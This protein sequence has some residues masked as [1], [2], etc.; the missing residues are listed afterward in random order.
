MGVLGSSGCTPGVI[1]D[2]PGVGRKTKGGGR[3]GGGWA[4]GEAGRP[5]EAACFQ[6]ERGPGGGREQW[7]REPEK[8]AGKERVVAERKR[9]ELWHQSVVFEPGS[10]V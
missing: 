3:L 1:W 2:S 6:V 7:E 5:E 9:V 4:D 8:T 10:E